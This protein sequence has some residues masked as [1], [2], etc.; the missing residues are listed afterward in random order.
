MKIGLGEQQFTIS[1]GTTVKRQGTRNMT[2]CWKLSD[3]VAIK[4]HFSNGH[5]ERLIRMAGI[6]CRQFDRCQ[7]SIV[8]RNGDDAFFL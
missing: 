4:H 1:F 6:V 5:A 8:E 3:G 7:Q 2:L